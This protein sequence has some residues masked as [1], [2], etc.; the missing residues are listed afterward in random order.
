MRTLILRLLG[1]AFSFYLTASLLSGFRL[2][3]TWQAY[4]LASGLFVI[5]NW[6][7]GPIIKLFLLPINLL[8]LGLFRWLTNVILLYLFD[9]L[10]GG[11]EIVA[12]RF[13]GFR[14]AAVSLPPADLSLFWVLVFAS[15]IISLANTV[16]FSLFHQD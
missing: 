2:E 8:T 5:F 3:P 11:L 1:T 9:L 15:L 13:E 16:F 12:Y 10:Y 4:L 6:V 14:S 7:A